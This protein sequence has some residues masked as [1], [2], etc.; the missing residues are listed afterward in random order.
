MS[1]GAE[2][3]PVTRKN[4]SLWLEGPYDETTKQNV[5]R[6]IEKRPAEAADAFYKTLSFGTGGMRGIMGDGTNRINLYTIRAAAQGLAN[7][8]LRQKA[9]SHG[10]SAF[11]GYDSRCNSRRFA[12]EA[13][14][15]F[16][17]NGIRA[18]LCS[19]IRPTPFV[20]FGC[21][22]KH[23]T[24]AIM[25]TASHN[26]PEYN[27]FK[28]YWDDGGQVSYPLDQEIAAEM[29]RLTNPDDVKTVS[30][31]DD[32][33][34]T[35]V[36][37]DL[38][39]VYIARSSRLQYYPD[40][41]RMHGNELNIVYTSLHG[42]GITLAPKIF[43]SWGFT[44]VSYVDQQVVPDPEFPTA[45]PPN[46]E[47]K[48]ALALGMKKLE[49]TGSDLLI[50]T[51][52]DADRVGIVAVHKG[53]QVV[54]TGNQIACLCLAHICEALTEGRKMPVNGAFIKTLV[55]TELFQAICDS[56]SRPCFNV[57]VGFK[58]VAEKIREWEN[59]T[60]GYEY[61]FGAEESHGYLLG[62]L[63]RDKDAITAS[64]LLCEAALHAKM[65]GLTLVDLLYKLYEKH[66]VYADKVL[67]IK[68]EDTKT[69]K[70]RMAACISKLRL[71]R[72]ETF[73]GSRILM[74]EDYQTL[75]RTDCLSGK[76]EPI[77]STRTDMILW[78]LADGARLVI[79]PS[80]TE[81]KIKLYCS[82][83]MAIEST[84]DETLK[85]CTERTD[86]FLSGLRSMID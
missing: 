39:E 48:T 30:T 69:G 35:L 76:T 49:E 46:P 31:L 45:S 73:E 32:P 78:K 74:A 26:P 81:P 52:P 4:L 24:T 56:Y 77:A 43:A 54:L 13:A 1:Q 50:A 67:S 79:R 58:Y 53:V 23:C 82:T 61:I 51:D 75:Q 55:T 12:E 66:G 85:K 11:I 63:T 6:L 16:A 38:D 7:Y 8:V 29:E 72:P 42:T 33:L 70:E 57:P 22:C 19:D 60:K 83:K 44:S 80:G 25:I 2:F 21:R 36:E 47:D 20:S 17:G 86:A 28:V 27:G 40:E 71:H 18:F 62:T 68:F 34:I 5:R 15:V 10:H 65:K 59:T 64:A 84:L 41:N 9:P 3:D 37:G 14:K